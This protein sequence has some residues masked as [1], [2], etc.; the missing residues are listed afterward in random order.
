M[1]AC[2][3][4]P[5]ISRIRSM[6]TP[7]PVDRRG[8]LRVRDPVQVARPTFGAPESMLEEG[9]VA[10]AVCGRDPPHPVFQSFPS[11]EAAGAT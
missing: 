10:D 8:Q 4:A 6:D 5:F 1:R 9:I 7:V 11:R 3:D 2:I